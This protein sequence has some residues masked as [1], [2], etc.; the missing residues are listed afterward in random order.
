MEEILLI[1]VVD[2]IISLIAF[3]GIWKN[4]ENEI[5]NFWGWPTAVRILCRLLAFVLWP[6]YMIPCVIYVLCIMLRNLYKS[7]VE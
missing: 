4:M 1:I 7:F 3:F 2:F 6:I 5:D